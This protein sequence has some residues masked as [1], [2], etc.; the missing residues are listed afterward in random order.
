ML[1]PR[2]RK[3]V[4][5]LARVKQHGARAGQVGKRPQKACLEQ[6]PN[7]SRRHSHTTATT[8]GAG[9][10]AERPI[11]GDARRSLFGPAQDRVDED[12]VLIRTEPIAPRPG[13]GASGG[14]IGL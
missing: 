11:P 9:I 1:V 2:P 5:G 7:S 6:C 3:G 8:T 10:S 14:I 12:P 13:G 4:R